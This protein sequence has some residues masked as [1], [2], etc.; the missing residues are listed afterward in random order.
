MMKVIGGIGLL[1]GG[2]CVGVI[3]SVYYFKIGA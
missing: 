3:S 2:F 1:L